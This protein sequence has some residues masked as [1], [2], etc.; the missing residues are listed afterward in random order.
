MNKNERLKWMKD[1]IMKD[2][3]EWKTK[4][5]KNKKMKGKNEWK[6]KNEKNER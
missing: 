6:T 3:N 4:T 1:K 5:K 2:K